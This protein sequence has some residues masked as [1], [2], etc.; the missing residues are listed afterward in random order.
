MT[1]EERYSNAL[2]RIGGASELLAL[3]EQV[4]TLLYNCS[5]FESKVKM[6]ELIAGAVEEQRSRSK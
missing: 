6:F 5:D 4:K 3:P 2:Q 1:L